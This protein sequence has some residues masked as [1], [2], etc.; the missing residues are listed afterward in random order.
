MSYIVYSPICNRSVYGLT[1]DN[2]CVMHEHVMIITTSLLSKKFLNTLEYRVL[3]G[4][5]GMVFGRNL[6]ES[7]ESFV[8]FVNCRPDL[9]CNVLVDEENGDVLP[10]RVFVKRR[11]NRCNRRLCVDNQEVLLLLF[12]YMTDSCEEE[13]SD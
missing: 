7:G 13:T 1:E 3:R 6:E 11:F 12:I 4:I 9:L 8:V 10:L 5:V 2:C